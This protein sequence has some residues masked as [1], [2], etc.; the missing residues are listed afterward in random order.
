MS[1]RDGV[2]GLPDGAG[3]GLSRR[4]LVGTAAWS[5]PVVTMVAASPTYATSGQSDALIFVP[6]ATAVVPVADQGNAYFDVSFAGAAFV[7]VDG[8]PTVGAQLT[9]TV[10]FVPFLDSPESEPDTFSHSPPPPSW[11]SATSGQAAAIHIF[12][13]AGVIASGDNVAIADGDYFGT[14]IEEQYGTFHLTFALDGLTSTTAAFATPPPPPAA[15]LRG[16]SRAG[17]S[18]RA[19][20]SRG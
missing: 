17:A 8:T 16:A 15:N 18:P 9:M 11:T 5:V 1:D 6:R 19:S 2:R 10:I 3:R 13:Y 12:T 14:A 4:T 20:R 7:Q